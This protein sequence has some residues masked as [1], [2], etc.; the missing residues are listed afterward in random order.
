MGLESNPWVFSINA[1][2]AP[3]PLPLFL[4]H[5]SW[6]YDGFG[7]LLGDIIA[8]GRRAQKGTLSTLVRSVKYDFESHVHAVHLDWKL[9]V[10]IFILR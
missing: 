6:F 10:W 2:P 3:N 5:I 9:R 1:Y 8:E 4:L 7:V